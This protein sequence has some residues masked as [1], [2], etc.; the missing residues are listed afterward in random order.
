MHE[1]LAL[2][3]DVGGTK[4]EAALVDQKGQLVPGSRFRRPTGHASTSH[5]L[6]IALRSAVEGAMSA[7]PVGTTVRG[8][9]VGSAGPIDI[10]AGTVSPLNLPSWRNFSLAE[11]VCDIVPGASVTL[12]IDGLCITLAEHW[13]G[14]ARG[15]GNLL[16]MVVSTGIGGG[17]ILNGCAIP[18]PTGN[19][20]HIG[21]IEVGESD[22]VCAC[23]GRGCLEAVASGPNTVAWAQSKGWGG[24]SGEDLSASYREGDA[25]ARAA[26]ERSGH[27]IGR[28]IG[29]VSSLLD[30]DV[31]TIGGGFSRVTPDLFG[32]IRAG[33]HERTSFDF[34]RRLKVVPSALTEE[35][36]LVGA[37]ALVHRAEL[38]S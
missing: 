28:A 8:V 1:P 36:P 9:G 21:H 23:G 35:G 12:R 4:V 3:I 38:L 33:L 5:T 11:L 37:G 14:T 32:F 22:A 17:L 10:D 26:I 31:V 34:M 20:G 6:V 27:A 30:L 2:A 16:G 7:L 29:S 24:A 15:V 25:I 18:G 13:V 19:A